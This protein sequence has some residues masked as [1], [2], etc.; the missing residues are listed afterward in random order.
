MIRGLRPKK[1]NP[2]V[3]KQ[4][5]IQW[6]DNI[7]RRVR[8]SGDTSS[9]R[10]NLLPYKPSETFACHLSSHSRCSALAGILRCAREKAV[11]LCSA[12]QTTSGIP[13][14]IEVFK[15]EVPR[16]SANSSDFGQLLAAPE[17]KGLAVLPQKQYSF[18]LDADQCIMA[19][20]YRMS[21]YPCQG[22]RDSWNQLSKPS[23]T[24]N[25]LEKICQ[26]SKQTNSTKMKLI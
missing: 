10:P 20:S 21:I 16:R 26:L 13:R 11:G 6:P 14:C 9:T 25:F 2:K 1:T 4:A 24:Q 22:I 5:R 17:G 23:G 15:K 12:P 7:F 3:C 19:Q 18:D 8:P